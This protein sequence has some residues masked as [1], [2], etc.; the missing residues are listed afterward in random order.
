MG[1]IKRQ[2]QSGQKRISEA[3][4]DLATCGLWAHHSTSEPLRTLRQT[5]SSWNDP[6]SASTVSHF[7]HVIHAAISQPV[8]CYDDRTGMKEEAIVKS[9]NNLRSTSFPGQHSILIL[10]SHRLP[11]YSVCKASGLKFRHRSQ[12][13]R[14]WQSLQLRKVGEDFSVQSVHLQ[15]A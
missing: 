7:P 2:M 12:T 15:V 8:F 1:V 13:A 6:G 9:E 3:S 5:A 4:F 11:K 10:L 14:E